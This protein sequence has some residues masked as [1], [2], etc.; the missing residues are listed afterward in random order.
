MQPPLSASTN[1]FRLPLSK[2]LYEVDPLVPVI[3]LEEG[4]QGQN[5]LAYQTIKP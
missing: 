1:F 4:L 5:M 2:E 3:C